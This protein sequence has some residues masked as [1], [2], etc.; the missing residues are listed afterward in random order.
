MHD[1]DEDE[2]DDGQRGCQSDLPLG[3]G[4]VVDLE[5]GHRRRQA[6]SA[7]GGDVDDVEARQGGDHRDRDADADLLAEAR[8]RDRPE[9]LDAS[10]RRRAGPTRRGR[11]RSCSCPVSSRTV[12]SPSR[13]QT[14]MTPT[15]G[16]AE[17]KS[18]SQARVT[19]PSPIADRTWLTRPD[20]DSSP[21]QMIPAAT[22]GMTCGQEQ[23]G[24]GR[25]SRSARSAMRWMTRATTSPRPT[26]MKREEH[27][28]LEGVEDHADEVRIGEDR[29]RS[30]SDRPTA[31]GR[32]RPSGRASTGT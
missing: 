16:S 25:R 15:A 24:P 11:G 23:D 8:E 21:L 10:P 13:T 6:G 14:P 5:P 17:S 19:P 2:Q 7:A 26:G 3:E 1:Q 22:S 18:P 30:S 29:R 28:E 32:C 31:T 20:V 12:Q 4:E 9:L 27:D